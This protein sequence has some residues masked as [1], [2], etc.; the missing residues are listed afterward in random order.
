MCH[1]SHPQLMHHRPAPSH[2]CLHV[3][4]IGAGIVCWRS[5]AFI[6]PLL[7]SLTSTSRHRETRHLLFRINVSGFNT[8]SPPDCTGL[9]VPCRGAAAASRYVRFS[10]LA[11]WQCTLCLYL[12]MNL[13]LLIS[14]THRPLM[15]SALTT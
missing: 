1:S 8:T 12:G 9:V 2:I 13:Y 15:L 5:S 14:L 11:V 3:L 7:N 10:S 4:P 6:F